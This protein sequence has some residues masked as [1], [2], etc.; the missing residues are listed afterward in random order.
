MMMVKTQGM[1]LMAILGAGQNILIAF[2]AQ[3]FV[4]F[5]L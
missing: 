3:I 2:M 5:L 1:I 4:R